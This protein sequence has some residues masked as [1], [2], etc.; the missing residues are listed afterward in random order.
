MVDVDKWGPT[1]FEFNHKRDGLIENFMAFHSVGDR[2][3]GR[4]CPGRSIATKMI[5]N[6]IVELGKVRR[7]PDF[8]PEGISA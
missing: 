7:S 2:T 4:V 5:M 1:A 3:N 8:K 6:I